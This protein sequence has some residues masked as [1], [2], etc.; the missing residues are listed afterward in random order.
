MQARRSVAS[1]A[2]LSAVCFG[3]RDDARAAS[4][5]LFAMLA[6][7]ARNDAFGRRPLSRASRPFAGPLVIVCSGW[8][9]SSLHSLAM[10]AICAF[11]MFERRLES[12]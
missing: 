2:A 3:R 12:T 6:S 10:T 8:P 9:E 5:K 7:K 1:L 4:L 11:E